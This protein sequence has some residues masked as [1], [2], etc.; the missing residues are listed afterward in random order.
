MRFAPPSLKRYS[1]QQERRI[2]TR[3]VVRRPASIQLP[4]PAALSSLPHTL[5]NAEVARSLT[6]ISAAATSIAT[7]ILTMRSEVAHLPPEQALA[8]F[9]IDVHSAGSRTLQPPLTHG[10][11]PLSHP[12]SCL[13][14]CVRCAGFCGQRGRRHRLQGGGQTPQ[15]HVGARHPPRSCGC[16]RVWLGGLRHCT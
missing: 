11:K 6:R 4:C 7:K 14:P 13:S 1:E 10:R 16:A 5:A 3:C 12:P 9:D 2:Y 15:Q 8:A